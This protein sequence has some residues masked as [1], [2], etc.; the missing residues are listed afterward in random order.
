MSG[1]PFALDV[2]RLLRLEWWSNHGCPVGSR[3]GDDG[4][5]SCGGCGLD[6]KRMPLEDLYVRV[7]AA[8]A[9]VAA[10]AWRALRGV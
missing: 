2:E 4:E 1:H 6:F 5:L 3:Y 10:E 7:G 9:K 8:R